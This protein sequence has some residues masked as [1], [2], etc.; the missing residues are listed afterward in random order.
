MVLLAATALFLFLPANVSRAVAA[1]D[2]PYS[3]WS[4][5]PPTDPGFFPIGVWL[6]S[7]AHAQEYKNIGVNMFVGFDGNLDQATLNQLAAAQMFVMPAQNPVGLTSPQRAWIRGW[8]LYDE[9]DDAQ[10]DGKGGYGVCIPPSTVVA[11]YNE[12]RAKDK[13]SPV[14]LNFGRGASKIDYEGRG[15]ACASDTAYYP[16]AIQGA[17]IISFD[18]Y[19]VADYN[20]RLEIVPDG[21]DNLKT[22]SKGNKIIWNFVEASPFDGGATPTEAQVRAEVWMSLI[23]GSRGILYFVHQFKPS[24]REDGIFNYPALVQAVTRI[25]EQ[26]QE[27]A[28]ALNAATVAGG[29]Q[30]VSSATGVPIDTM[31]K[32][33]GAMTY[34]FAVAMRDGAAVGTF[35]V[36]GKPSGMVTVLGENREIAMTGGKFSDGFS[37]YGVHLYQFKQ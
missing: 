33:V 25:D 10:P 17:D 13:S 35:T 37:G 9:P 19:P 3:A 22:W 4:N 34:V 15:A 12:T 29:V 5:G 11:K 6:Q 24:F 2:S 23:H 20:G 18:I 14:F 28:P 26:I 31:E 21:V 27:L 32:R 8:D 7:P 30:A 16:V 1:N 36:S